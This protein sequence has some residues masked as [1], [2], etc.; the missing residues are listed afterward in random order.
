MY[1]RKHTEAFVVAIK[2]T[3]SEANADKARCM[4]MCRNQTAE[5]TRNIKN[6]NSSFEKMGG[7][8][9]QGKP[10]TNQNDIQEEIKIRFK[11]GITCYHSVQNRLFSRWL[12]KNANIK[13]YRTIVLPVVWYGCATWSLT[14]REEN[15]FRVFENRETRRI[16]GPK[17]D[18]VTGDWIKL[19][20]DLLNELYCSPKI[21]RVMN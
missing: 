11:S 3:G 1:Y 7:F 17:R 15:R 13:I 5:Q 16:F 9:H 2:V 8:I 6:E 20:N 12:N 18:E 21:V 10:L 14:L 4:I 19:H